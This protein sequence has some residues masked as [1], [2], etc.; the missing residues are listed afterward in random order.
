M[1]LMYDEMEDELL[2]WARFRRRRFV[3]SGL[4]TYE[5]FYSRNDMGRRLGRY[6]LHYRLN[7]ERPTIT[8]LLTNK[9]STRGR[10]Q[11]APKQLERRTRSSSL[12]ANWRVSK[13]GDVMRPKQ[14]ADPD[15]SF[16]K[17]R[18][19]SRAMEED[20]DERIEQ[21]EKNQQ[22]EIPSTRLN[23]PMSLPDV[24]MPS[25]PIFKES[26][27]EY[28]E[29]DTVR[30]SGILPSEMERNSEYGEEG[31]DPSPL[32]DRA[33]DTTEF[34]K[35]R[36]SGMRDSSFSSNYTPVAIRNSINSNVNVVAFLG[37]Y[38]STGGRRSIRSSLDSRPSFETY[39]MK[40]GKKAASIMTPQETSFGRRLRDAKNRIPLEFRDDL[41][42]HPSIS[43]K[44]T[45]KKSVKFRAENEIFVF[46]KQDPI[47]EDDEV[48]VV[49]LDQASLDL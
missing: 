45:K 13:C 39:R 24:K 35:F 36:P 49:E 16:F 48:Y 41:A 15:F 33:S 8:I 27:A 5:E 22:E 21:E 42:L 44:S 25:P 14:I 3:K 37:G 20:G 32:N 17:H 2:M 38:R 31:E 43:K 26:I 28:K 34:E 7:Q 19:A 23:R 9:P 12:D 1:D 29:A 40:R 11:S 4:S 18:T 6:S 10:V 46:E 47:D 30:S